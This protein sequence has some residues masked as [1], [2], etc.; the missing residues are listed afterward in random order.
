MTTNPKA[1]WEQQ[2]PMPASRMSQRRTQITGHRGAAGL[3]PENTLPALEK[4]LRL[5]IDGVEIDIQRS[6]DGHLV[7]FHDERL[8]RCTNGN[9]LLRSATLAEL[10]A[11]DAGAW[12]DPAYVGTR[13]PTFREVLDFM[14]SNN[15][16][17]HVELKDPFY[18]PGVAAEVVAL[19]REY[20][21]EER[22]QIRSF[23]H[24]ALHDV[25]N[26][27]PELAISE[28][29]YQ[30]LPKADESH[31]RSVNMDQSVLRPE[32]IADFHARG[33]KV[34]AWTV[35]DLEKARRFIDAGID[36]LTTDYPDRLLTLFR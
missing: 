29:W 6:A 17:L 22:V 1:A 3:A 30:H 24:P 32:H 4:A 33:Q 15:M 12:F 11:L 25:F 5:G 2:R 34:S 20:K 16:I 21:F 27:A 19:L 13:I 26:L 28:L 31:F 18:F 23:F 7:V 10:Q 35:N 14:Q 9:G 36:G 8:D